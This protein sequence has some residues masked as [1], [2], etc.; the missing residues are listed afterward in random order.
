MKGNNGR[1]R[2]TL[3]LG[4]VAALEEKC[5]LKLL[6]RSAIMALYMILDGVQAATRNVTI[7]RQKSLTNPCSGGDDAAG[8][9]SLFNDL[10]LVVIPN[11]SQTE[12]GRD[13]ATISLCMCFI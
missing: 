9:S 3:R 12:K 13:Q 5:L 8:Y 11:V 4:M 1:T 10:Q 7:N 2:L 6:D